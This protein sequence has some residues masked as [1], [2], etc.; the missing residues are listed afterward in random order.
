[1]FTSKQ[2][3]FLA[4]CAGAL[5]GEGIGWWT[6]NQKDKSIK[7]LLEANQYNAE[8]ISVHKGIVED[9][10]SLVQKLTN[11]IDDPEVLKKIITD[12]EF[13]RIVRHGGFDKT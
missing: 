6:A 11:Q 7:I 8:A 1:M 4:F 9:A 5:V 12:E 2:I 10:I 3:T 13:E